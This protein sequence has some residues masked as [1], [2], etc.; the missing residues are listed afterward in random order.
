MSTEV[1]A[2]RDLLLLVSGDVAPSPASVERLEH[3]RLAAP[4]QK[5]GRRTVHAGIKERFPFLRTEGQ[6]DAILCRPEVAGPLALRGLLSF[7]DLQRL[8]A[9]VAR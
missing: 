2:C 4:D 7:D 9:F 1:W 8:Q 3:V 5:D 6:G